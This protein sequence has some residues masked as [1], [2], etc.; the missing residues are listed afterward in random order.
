MTASKK[1]RIGV[2]NIKLIGN[3]HGNEAVGREILLH[4]LEVASKYLKYTDAFSKVSLL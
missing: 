4:F 1:G 2:P 3:V